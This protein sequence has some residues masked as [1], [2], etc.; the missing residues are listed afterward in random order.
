ML[1]KVYNMYMTAPRTKPIEAAVREAAPEL[2]LI[3]SSP[4]PEVLL[5]LLVTLGVDVGGLGVG[6]DVGGL[7]VG[8][9]G[10]GVGPEGM[11]VGPE[12]GD[13][14]VNEAAFT[15]AATLARKTKADFI[16]VSS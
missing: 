14:V 4:P 1:D 10:L 13:A 5:L 7:G 12:G 2:N 15:E 3:S 9:E 6:V 8:P 16:L 11:G